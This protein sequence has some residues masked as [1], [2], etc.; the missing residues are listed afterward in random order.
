MTFHT[1]SLTPLKLNLTEV[2]WRVKE[3]NVFNDLRIITDFYNG[4]V[5]NGLLAE[6]ARAAAWHPSDLGSTP[7]GSG[8]TWPG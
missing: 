6:M 2:T 4:T 1:H 3:L 5:A 7:R 8:F